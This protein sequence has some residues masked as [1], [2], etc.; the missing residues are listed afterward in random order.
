MTDAPEPALSRESATS[1]VRT[2]ASN[3]IVLWIAFVLV[4]FWLGM[5]GLYSPGLPLGD[6][7]LVYKVWTDQ[8]LVAHFWVGINTVWVYPIGAI[9]PMIAAFA[10]GPTLYTST[11]ISMVMLLD[12]LAFATIT[13]WYRSRG[14]ADVAWW[15]LGFLL[16][17]G[18][19]A[20]GRI[21]SVTIPLG[22][23][24]VLLVAKRPAVASIILTIAMW[25]KVWPAALIG[26]IV[27]ASKRRWQ[28]AATALATSAGVIAIALS[29]GSGGN[30]LSF[31][32]QQTGR[33][34]QVESPI[35]TFW[36]WQAAAGVPGTFVYY[37]TQILTFQV[38][39]NG[40]AIA[41]ALMTPL[42]AVAVLG[43]VALGI[44]ATRRG[45]AAT[46]LLA[47]LALALVVT[48]IAFNK[49]GSPQFMTWLAVPVIL[50]LATRGRAFR[51]PA[52]VA[53]ALAALTQ[54]VYPYLYTELLRLNPALLLVISVRNALLFVLLGWAVRA[55]VRSVAVTHLPARETD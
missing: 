52:G 17:L 22:I 2:A 27:I 34:L 51:F 50:G 8:A 42:L 13:G 46:T 41:A 18:P 49:V 33:G 31:I 54:L 32:T 12:A 24:G 48:L 43:V 3:R 19:I 14:R 44:W 35:A 29:F 20:L 1:R 9:V 25:V 53:L 21:D 26:A 39:G 11:W 30:V 47:P 38:E 40:V 55:V 10:L 45:V 23:V 36:L 28:V 4:H 7:T 37:S 6:V 16:L 15:W 5:L